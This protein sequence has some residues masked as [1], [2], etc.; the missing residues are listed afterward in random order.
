MIRVGVFHPQKKI[1]IHVTGTRRLVRYVLKNETRHNAEINIIFI[2]DAMMIQMNRKYL[3]HN[4]PTDVLCFLLDETKNLLNG[5]VYVNIDQARR[6]AVE[7]CA[8]YRDEYARLIIHGVLHLAGYDDA[9]KNEREIMTEL[10]NNYLS[11][12]RKKNILL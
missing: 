10:E 6:Q 1:K 12:I 9:T 8:T 11:K 5:E 2:N 7:Y 4:Y 3:R